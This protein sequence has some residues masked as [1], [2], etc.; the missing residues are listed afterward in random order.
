[1]KH[2]AKPS[3]PMRRAALLAAAAGVA[4]SLG[5]CAM[6]HQPGKRQGPGEKLDPWENWNRKV[7]SFNEGLD[8]HV[9][10][11]VATG[12]QKVVPEF[13]RTGIDNFFTNFS[14]AWSAVNHL[15]QG[16]W[17]SGFEMTVRV[18]T[19]T[20]FGL[21]GVLD[22]AGEAGLESRPEDLGQTLG[23]W[24]FGT[25][26]YIVWPL[27]GPSSVRDSVGLPFDLMASPSSVIN[28][29]ASKFEIGTLQLVNK[30]A[31]LLGATRVLDDIALDKYTF[32]RDAYLARVREPGRPGL[33]PDH[34]DGGSDADRNPLKPAPAAPA[35]AASAPV[36]PA[37]P[38]APASAA[39]AAQ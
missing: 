6:T 32:V 8:E 27:F 18:T 11:P 12:Y 14:D 2:R 20:V 7:F 5:G 31:N 39:S 25:G 22:V 10:K 34:D 36:A 35:E 24:G 13:A 15:L 1:M 38:A 26:A 17:Q 19:N 37:A 33:Y 21:G 3:A 28:D 4:I 9:L 16:K 29:G 30:R 23:K